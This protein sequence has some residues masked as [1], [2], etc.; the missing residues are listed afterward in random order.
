MTKILLYLCLPATA[1]WKMSSRSPTQL[2]LN[3]FTLAPLNLAPSTMELWF[4]ASETIKSPL[5]AMA[6]ITV[7]FVAKPMPT[8]TAASLPTYFAV[9]SSTSLMSGL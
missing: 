3:A 4:S 6:G 1:S 8:T 2:C 9:T 7:E 5:P